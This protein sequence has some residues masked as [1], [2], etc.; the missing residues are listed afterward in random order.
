MA[1]SEKLISINTFAVRFALLGPIPPA[2]LGSRS[3]LAFPIQAARCQHLEKPP[4]RAPLQAQSCQLKSPKLSLAL[5]L[6]SYF[7]GEFLNW[8]CCSWHSHYL[9]FY[10]FPWI[11]SPS[12]IPHL[13]SKTNRTFSVFVQTHVQDTG[14]RQSYLFTA[15]PQ[16]TYLILLISQYS[17]LQNEDMNPYLSHTIMIMINEMACKQKFPG[18]K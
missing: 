13:L 9:H 11:P 15:W 14:Q 16:A 18:K 4:C 17:Y 2:Y 7:Y 6:I 1:T 5:V 8:P 3:F 10:L 12:L